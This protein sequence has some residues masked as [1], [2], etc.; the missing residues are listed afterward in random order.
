MSYIESLDRATQSRTTAR[1]KDIQ[2]LRALAVTLVVAFHAFPKAIPGGF[3]GVDVFFV[4]SGFLITLLLLREL[5]DTG[6]ISLSRFY[7]RR[8]RRLAPA[9]LLTTAATVVAAA[10]VMGPVQ[11]LS[12]LR[13]AV[14]TSVYLANVRFG[15]S[16]D[17]YFTEGPGSPFLH[18]WSLAVEEQ[19][20]L[21]APVIL[22]VVASLAK[23]R[24]RRIL[25]WLF[26]AITTA[27]LT[28]S[29]FLT[30][31]EWGH[32]YFSLATR[33]WELSLGAL[34]AAAVFSGIRLPARHVAATAGAVAILLA[35]FAYSETTPFPGIVASV[36]TAGAALI[37]WAGASGPF[38]YDRALG[39]SP[40]QFIGDASYSLYLW[41]WPAL[42]LGRIALGTGWAQ[43]IAMLIVAS[44]LA[45]ASYYLA[46]KRLGAIRMQSRPHQVVAAGIAATF[47]ATAALTVSAATV[48]VSGHLTASEPE[49]ILSS[50]EVINGRI[51][52]L[53][54]EVIAPESVPTNLKP[55]LADIAEDLAPVFTN[56]C[57]SSGLE[58]C[59]GGDPTGT[60][61][62]VLAGDSHAGQWWPA[63]DVAAKANGWKL[64]MV[65]K[66]GCP[67]AF[68]DISRADTDEAWPDCSAWQEAAADAVAGL[69]ADV[70][71]WA[72]NVGGYSQK[73]SLTDHFE[74]SWTAGA[75][76]MLTSLG[77]TATVV[78]L[79]QQ[80]R[81]STD[82]AT[83]LG[84]H[85]DAVAECSAPRDEVVPAELN[86]MI[87]EIAADS[88]AYYVDVADILCN[89]Q[90]PVVDHNMA[91]YRDSSHLTR[92]YA[93]YL[94]PVFA[95]LVVE[96]LGSD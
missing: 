74:S 22:V 4:I 17:G 70:I 51:V 87:E 62:V 64:Y 60:V 38:R 8:V 72:N 58:V 92:T 36:P 40:I 71:V 52:P 84:T 94:A 3:I 93:E 85:L 68:V 49:P 32:A 25:P 90:C 9:A 45:I 48:P 42:V 12:V 20:Y 5:D 65:G 29:S 30:S 39:W 54:P 2:A 77:D 66:N 10:L 18:F 16:P 79:G 15:M 61:R 44:L 83:C 1:R 95:A 78:S 35:A 33:A 59:E 37:I 23:A 81:F 27:S 63:A 96:A 91:M 55:S 41:H 31:A 67:L 26:A 73:R 76:E 80:P 57:F 88:G 43:S 53:S 46:E 7:A 28:A 56:G 6:H 75:K 34:V 19:F 21:I 50:G 69:D 47:A 13:D 82:P 14:W 89:A 86:S 24:W 11:L